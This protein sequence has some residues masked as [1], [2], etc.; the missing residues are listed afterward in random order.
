[1]PTRK[2]KINI[3]ISNV[4][5]PGNKTTFPPAFQQKSRLHY[6]S[7][8]FNTVELNS[9]FYKTPLYST[10]EKWSADTPDDFQFSIKLSKEITH[11]K[12]LKTNLSKIETLLEAA[13]GL[14]KKKGC[15]LIQFPGKITLDYFEQVE[16]I[17][18]HVADYDSNHEWKKSVEFRHNSW[19][20]SESWELLDENGMSMVLHDIPK[21]F[22]QAHRGK[23]KFVYL[24]FHG[25]NGDY[26][27]SYSDKI[28]HERAEAIQQWT[29]QGKDV[30]VYFNNTIGDAFIDANRLKHL[31][32]LPVAFKGSKPASK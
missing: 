1:M 11:V 7:H 15:L 28:L 3:G 4:V 2:G 10:F 6:Y 16:L 29:K 23:A 13:E 20:T 14:G 24:R 22:I 8:L 9:T 5:I 30:Y 32:K 19:Y 26:R 18:Q 31:L 21:S 17:L 12:E 25:P 27:E